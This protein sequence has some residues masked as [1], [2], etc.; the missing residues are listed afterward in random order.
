MGSVV[1]AC[2]LSSC[3]A[4]ASFLRGMWDLPGPGLEPV[5]PA[6]AGGC[7]TTAPPGKPDTHF[8]RTPMSPIAH[9]TIVSTY[10]IA[11]TCFEKE[12]KTTV[13]SRTYFLFWKDNHCCQEMLENK[14]LKWRT[15][16]LLLPD[17]GGSWGGEGAGERAHCILYL[18]LGQPRPEPPSIPEDNGVPSIHWSSSLTQKCLCHTRGPREVGGTAPPLS[19]QHLLPFISLSECAPESLPTAKRKVKCMSIWN[20]SNFPLI[21]CVT[22]G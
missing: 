4:R 10:P 1:V 11:L 18:G 20:L 5:C 16:H 13:Y 9:L 3:G 17:G 22:L 6:S 19:T 15:Q 21:Y 8:L 2:R 14:G 12:S 7:L